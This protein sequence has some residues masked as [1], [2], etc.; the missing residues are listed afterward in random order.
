MD[1][2]HFCE[3]YGASLDRPL[4]FPPI[5]CFVGLRRPLLALHL[6]GLFPLLFVNTDFNAFFSSFRLVMAFRFFLRWLK[7]QLSSLLPVHS[8]NASAFL[9]SNLSADHTISI[10]G[11]NPFLSLYLFSNF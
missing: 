8:A 4:P 11:Y 3:A 5:F 10:Q 2:P 7:R 9:V 1:D 6:Q